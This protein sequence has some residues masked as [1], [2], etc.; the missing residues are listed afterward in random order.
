MVHRSQARDSVSG[1]LSIRLK[2]D[3]DIQSSM[4]AF[5]RHQSR[6]RTLV[7]IIVLENKMLKMFFS[8]L[9]SVSV[10]KVQDIGFNIKDKMFVAWKLVRYESKQ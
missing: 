1:K 9:R 4:S 5:L 3:D 10:L 8:H 2:C 6:P 7:M